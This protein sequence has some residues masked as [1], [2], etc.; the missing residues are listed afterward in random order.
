VV[1]FAGPTDW[2]LLAEIDH[3]H[4]AYRQL[5]GYTPDT[6]AADMRGDLKASVSPISHA[7]ADDPP[8]LLVHGDM[9]NIVPIEHAR[10]LET[11]LRACSVET[12]LY[13]VKGAGHNVSGAP[14][15]ARRATVFIRKH[16]GISVETQPAR[17]ASAHRSPEER[18]SSELSPI[19]A[20]QPTEQA[21]TRSGLPAPE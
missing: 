14:G 12:E 2:S 15:A 10:R 17:A 16:L 19:P 8:T 21:G 13:V 6:T 4:P 20:P 11:R 18:P 3:R 7:S 5:L 9:D 1:S